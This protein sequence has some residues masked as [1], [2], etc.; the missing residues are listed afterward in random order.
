MTQL[1]AV[2]GGA[3]P[4][5]SLTDVTKTYTLGKVEVPALRGVTLE[6]FPGEFISIAG[7]SGSGKT[8][9]LNLIGCV[10]TATAG[11]V[12]VDGQDTKQLTERQLTNL[13]LHTIGFIFQSF[14]LVSVLS[15][16]QNVEFPL[17]LQR[18]LSAPERRQRVM[19]LLEQVGL[20]KHAKHRPN[21]LSGGQRQRVAVARALVTRPKLVLADEPTAN[22]DSVT[23]QNIIDL[24]KELNR[25][26]GTTFIFST[27]DAK[28][29]N[30][31]NAVVRLA[32]GK[33]LD[34]IT[35]AEA[36]KAMAAGAEG[37]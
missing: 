31:A 8:T 25:K 19:T 4:I 36:Q 27:H 16:F 15:V 12:R 28:V 22:L 3:K 1:T 17:L 32:D 14:N 23:G 29:M 9:A 26:E 11:V 33:I 6:V 5:V 20:E 21:E 24:M 30:H 37:H 35:P 18:K 2:S 13:R 34:R 10:D 7:P